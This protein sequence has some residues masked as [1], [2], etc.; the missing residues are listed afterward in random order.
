MTA[1]PIDTC[2]VAPDLIVHDRGSGARHV[3]PITLFQDLTPIHPCKRLTLET[4]PD[5]LDMRR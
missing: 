2:A 4:T 5:N 1:F 3:K